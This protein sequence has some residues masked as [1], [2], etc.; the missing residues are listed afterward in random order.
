MSSSRRDFLTH[1]LAG[2]AATALVPTLAKAASIASAPAAT[3]NVSGALFDPRA[4][5]KAI[6]SKAKQLW[7]VVYVD[8]DNTLSIVER[9]VE[10][11]MEGG[12]DAVVLELGK[13]PAPL[14]R[15]LA[16]VKAKYPQVK[17]GADYL[18]GDADQYGYKTS[19]ALAKEFNLDIVW[20]DF[21]GVDLIEELPEVSLHD[22]EA[23]R[24]PGAFYCSGVHMKYGTLRNPQKTLEQSALQALGWVEGVIITGPKTGVPTDPDRPRR[25]RQVIGDYPLGL[26]SGVSAE[27]FPSIGTHVDFCLVNT[28]ISDENHRLIAAK[29]R[30]LRRVMDSI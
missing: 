11:A 12:A 9:D 18:G 21:A 10:A 17:V 2:V 7:P 25:V 23:H 14:V 4:K 8:R 16:H 3:P 22:I 29:V 28:S 24:V 6:S 19:F 1:G 5:L 13:D 26:A 30:E 15:A 27:N 20:T